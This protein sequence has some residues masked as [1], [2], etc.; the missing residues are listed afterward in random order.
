M[1]IKG[2]MLAIMLVML[3]PA[4]SAFAASGSV[5]PPTVGLGALNSWLFWPSPY[6]PKVVFYFGVNNNPVDV[7]FTKMPPASVYE[8]WAGEDN[9]APL[10]WYMQHD[11][12]LG[13]NDPTFGGLF[14]AQGVTY[15]PTIIRVMNSEHFAP[16][17][18]G[19]YNPPGITTPANSTWSYAYGWSFGD[20][21][22]I[23]HNYGKVYLTSTAP[24]T[25]T[26]TTTTPSSNKTGTG[27]VVTKTG[28][29]TGTKPGGSST[30]PRKSS[31]KPGGTGTK[32]GGSSTKTQN[33]GGS[34]GT[35]T[36]KPNTVVPP[37]PPQ[38]R[39]ATMPH[40][41]VQKVRQEQR[42][43]GNHAIPVRRG[44]PWVIVAA[45]AAVL[46]GLGW[47]GVARWRYRRRYSFR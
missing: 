44:T 29:G 14:F 39:H 25:T 3:L 38:L 42:N 13:K 40:N 37:Y 18:L 31:T 6:D 24:T 17:M 21:P 27:T 32:P 26:T 8:K 1:K 9:P 12:P 30:K 45:G 35:T 15:T 41:Y 43:L 2:T 28:T 10:I 22:T 5:P 20:T 34:V 11:D 33:P 47:F 16:T 36:V 46:I 4:V 7:L 19:G 23:A